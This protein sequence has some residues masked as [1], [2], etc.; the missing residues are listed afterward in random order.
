MP[1]NRHIHTF[2]AV[3]EARH[4]VQITASVRRCPVSVGLVVGSRLWRHLRSTLP[5]GD[6]GGAELLPGPVPG[7]VV[8]VAALRAAL[9]D[10]G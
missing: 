3:N 8:R 9:P 2:T 1:F 7:Q 6:L 5:D 10:Q 4:D